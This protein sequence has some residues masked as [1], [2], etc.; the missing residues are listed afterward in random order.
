MIELF[1]VDENGTWIIEP[2]WYFQI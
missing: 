1:V 2:M